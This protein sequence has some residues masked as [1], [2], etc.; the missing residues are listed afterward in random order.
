MDHPN[1]FPMDSI[2][3]WIHNCR[4][5]LCNL[6]K[7]GIL[8]TTI[9]LALKYGNQGVTK[10]PSKP[11]DHGLPYNIYSQSSHDANFTMKKP[12]EER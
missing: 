7:T 12:M 1:M 10:G 5:R 2:T 4:G 11:Q 9:I 3:L 6:K 8:D